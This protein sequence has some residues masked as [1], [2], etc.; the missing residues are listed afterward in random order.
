MKLIDNTVKDGQMQM[1]ELRLNLSNHH[2][3]NKKVPL[4]DHRLLVNKIDPQVQ[5]TVLKIKEDL[6]NNLNMAALK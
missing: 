5:L 3:G 4:K 6:L 1:K 2:M